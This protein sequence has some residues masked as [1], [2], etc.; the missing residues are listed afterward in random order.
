M[1]FA[2]PLIVLGGTFDRLHAGHKRLLTESFARAQKVGIGLAVDALVAKSPSKG[3]G[4][5]PFEEREALLKT[6]LRRSYPGSRWYVLALD[7]PEGKIHEP[8]I[9]AL[10]VSEETFPAAVQANKWRAAHHMDPLTLVVV[11]RVY[12]EDLLPI[13]SRRIRAGDIDGEGRRFR[14]VVLGFA[15]TMDPGVRAAL[16]EAWK[17]LMPGPQ[18][19]MLDAPATPPAAEGTAPDY[20][21]ELERGKSRWTITVTDRDGAV[22]EASVAGEGPGATLPTLTSPIS[23]RAVAAGLLA[24]AFAPR[25][26]ARSGALPPSVVI[27][28]DAAR[29]PGGGRWTRKVYSPSGVFP[30]Q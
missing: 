15:P 22:L 13:A 2:L 20:R 19:R 5:T 21:V 8:E 18:I 6:W 7:H 16:V 29:W 3:L 10:A 23:L 11:G 4:V 24:D 30:Y 9:P 26:L 1:A 27:E 25:L 28:G 14:P 17:R 12:G